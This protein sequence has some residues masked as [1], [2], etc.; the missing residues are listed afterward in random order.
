M[1]MTDLSF[2]SCCLS[3]SCTCVALLKRQLLIDRTISDTN[4]TVCEETAHLAHFSRAKQLA[5]SRHAQVY[6]CLLVN[7]CEYSTVCHAWMW[8]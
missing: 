2:V 3:L 6:S 4:S 8:R 7:V 5:Q 1:F